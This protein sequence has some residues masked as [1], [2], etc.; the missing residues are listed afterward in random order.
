MTEKIDIYSMGNVLYVIATSYFP[1]SYPRKYSLEEVSPLIINGTTPEVPQHVEESEDPAVQ[2]ILRAMRKCFA[3]EPAQRPSAVE[4]A[5]ELQ[6]VYN[7]LYLNISGYNN[8]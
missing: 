5:L 7:S 8:H 3:Y 2:A 6:G 4:V 1:Y